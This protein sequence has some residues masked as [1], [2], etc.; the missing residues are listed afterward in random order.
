[1]VIMARA[2]VELTEDGCIWVGGKQN[3]R[4][5]EIID[6]LIHKCFS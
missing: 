4:S 1:M 5:G 3:M 2:D 6:N